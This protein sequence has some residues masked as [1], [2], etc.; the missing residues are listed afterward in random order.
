MQD[1]PRRGIILMISATII[2]AIQDG[3]S[4]YLAE[5]YDIIT[6][7]AIRYWFFVVFVCAYS[8]R[9]SG[10]FTQAAYTKQPW[11]QAGRGVLLVLQI[12]VAVLGF[13]QVGL[14]HF[15][16]IFASYPLMVMALSVPLL[17]ETVGWRRWLAVGLG[18]AGVL[19]ILRPGS[20]LFDSTALVPLCAAIMM[21]TYGI[22]TRYAARQDSAETSFFWTGIA[23]ALTITLIVPFFWTPPQGQDWWWMG[24]LCITGASAHYL[25]ISALNTTHASTVQPFAYFQLVFAS[26]IGIVVFADALDRTLI[27]GSVMIVGSGLFA[28]NR[29][30]RAKIAPSS[31][32]V[33]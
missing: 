31:S 3:I 25:L 12:C 10:G 27:I 29:E 11:V 6:I 32:A 9:K 22:L 26:T 15:H 23:G 18:F 19:V 13:T 4:R 2:F 21:A 16:A 30:R 14:V 7:V 5:S 33:D 24:L 17:K 8:A 28:L 1:N 20:T